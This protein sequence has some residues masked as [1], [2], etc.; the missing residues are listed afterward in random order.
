MME[1]K[2]KLAWGAIGYA[3]AT[4]L[5]FIYAAAYYGRFDIA[6][7]NYA[8]VLDFVLISL[9]NI[10][11]LLMTALLAAHFVVYVITV[12]SIIYLLILLV[13][14]A[15]RK[16]ANTL[17]ERSRYGWMERA[18]TRLKDASSRI[19]ER[20]R[21]F[22]KEVKRNAV[23]LIASPGERVR[24]WMTIAIAAGGLAAIVAW[25]LGLMDA[26]CI[27]ENKQCEIN[28]VSDLISAKGGGNDEN[29]HGARKG[30]LP[31]CGTYVIPTA[32]VSHLEFVPRPSQQGERFY[33]RSAKRQDAHG[34]LLDLPSCMT[35]LGAVENAQFLV[36]FGDERCSTKGEPASC[37][38][39]AVHRRCEVCCASCS[40]VNRRSGKPC[41]PGSPCPP[42]E[43]GPQGEAGPQGDPGPQGERGPPG[44]RG[45]DG[46]QVFLLPAAAPEKIYMRAGTT[47]T[48]LHKDAQLQG[49]DAGQGVCL[50]K[51]QRDWLDEFRGAV[52]ECVD[53][54]EDPEGEARD[55][56]IEVTGYASIA[57]ASVPGVPREGGP[58]SDKFNCAIANMRAH[59]VAAF[60]TEKE[61]ETVWQCPEGEDGFPPAIRLDEYC[62][63]D[64]DIPPLVRHGDKQFAVRADQWRNP[65]QM[66]G[67]RPFYDGE[68]PYP[69]LYGVEML[70]RSVDIR[71]ARDFCKVK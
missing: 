9:S 28:G 55:P 49:E 53:T 29:K 67:G 27:I 21:K 65:D 6:F 58:E 61:E 17:Q 41:S 44:E 51:Q 50:T 38:T 70:N 39:R 64:D 5:G 63:R 2:K 13:E 22:D 48:L 32:N 43:P 62:P 10:R 26:D 57:P 7:L 71:V 30:A 46:G 16:L 20:R 37:P 18:S 59:A 54:V 15:L 56:I 25:R 36:H 34:G 31:W 60:L 47:F 45:R 33:V 66:R 1:A 8:T 23:A 12:L 19:K 24:T 14:I 40:P 42:G 52:L 4:V 35:Y 69:R 11:E 68:L 3:Y